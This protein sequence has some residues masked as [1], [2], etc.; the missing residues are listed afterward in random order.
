MEEATTLLVVVL[1]VASALFSGAEAALVS[2]NHLQLRQIEGGRT[3]LSRT[4]RGLL[5]DPQRLLNSLLVGNTL[6]NA[7]L[8]ATLTSLALD[9]FGPSGLKVAIPA[10]TVLILFFCEI[11]PKTFGVHFPRSLAY[12]AAIPL[13]AVR[14]L[15]APLTWG[16]THMGR[17]FLAL[18]RI[19]GAPEGLSR[20]VTRT[21]LRAVLEEIDEGS[22][23]SKVESRLVQNILS[24]SRTTA[25]EVMTPR[26]DLI[27]APA[28]IT[29]AE[30]LELITTSKHS[31]IPIYERTVDGIVG[32]VSSRA[33]LL[34][35]TDRIGALVQPV[36][37][38][39]D[40]A[41][42]DRVFH[43]MRKERHRMA[44][45]VNEYGDTVGIITRED[46]VEEVVGELFDEYEKGEEEIVG[47]EE[48]LCEVRG[49]VS[50][51]DLGERMGVEFPQEHVATVSG[52]LCRLH[53]GFPRKGTVLGWRDLRFEILDVGRHRVLRARVRRI[54]AEEEA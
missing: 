16:M 39:P 30:L 47:L 4:L 10:A 1:V 44:I 37:Y 53:G 21:E 51:Q 31:R 18:L 36:L 50:L 32:Y 13:A 9:R 23:M 2:L 42:A 11:L 12:L 28:T 20:R 8:S 19:P 52:F 43:D 38:V 3:R 25:E 22:G 6:V 29:R 35:P 24:F 17:A 14:P 34:D 5:R 26:V 33:F 54:P 7:G 49:S 15:L 41:P 46:L 40:K 48:D 27:A 45:V